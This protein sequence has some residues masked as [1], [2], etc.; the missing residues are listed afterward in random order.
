MAPLVSA[1][2]KCNSRKIC[3]LKKI[4]GQEETHIPIKCSDILALLISPTFKMFQNMN[5]RRG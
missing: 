1:P 4:L 5:T 2:R 3:D